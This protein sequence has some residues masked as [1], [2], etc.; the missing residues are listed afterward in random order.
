MKLRQWTRAGAVAVAA[1]LAL[2]ACA[3]GGETSDTPDEEAPKTL[4]LS[5]AAPP[6]N[7]QI[8]NWS[9]GESTLFLSVYDTIVTLTGDGQLAPGIAESWEYDDSRTELTL[10]IRDGMTFTSGDPVDAEAV[11]ASLEAALVGASTQGNLAS[12][13]AVEATDESTVVVTLSAPDAAVVPFLAGTGGAVGDP[14]ALTAEESKAL[15]GRFG[16]V[17]TLA[18]RFHRWLALRAREEP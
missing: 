12:I 16:C 10:D 18:G 5:V 3:G 9:G 14:E 6:S 15:A 2:T 11:V 4:R 7:F 1:G 17:R 13:E 8:G